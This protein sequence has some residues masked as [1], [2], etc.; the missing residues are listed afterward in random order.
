MQCAV[1]LPLHR[2]TIF[3]GSP[4]IHVFAP[5]VLTNAADACVHTCCIDRPSHSDTSITCSVHARRKPY[6][7]RTRLCLGVV[8]F[9]RE[10]RECDSVDA[11]EKSGAYIIDKFTDGEYM[12]YPVNVSKDNT[13]V[14][15]VVANFC[16]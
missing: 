11:F 16:Y 15:V 7:T 1:G 12:R 13:I 4:P 5:M 2:H 9:W 14:F 10:Y 8:V 6:F 3:L